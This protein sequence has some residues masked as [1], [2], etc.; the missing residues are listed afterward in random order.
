MGSL[1]SLR[2]R[3]DFIPKSMPEQE[4][5]PKYVKPGVYYH[6]IDISVYVA[7]LFDDEAQDGIA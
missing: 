5:S 6:V 1:R 3:E 7:D 2:K 4:E